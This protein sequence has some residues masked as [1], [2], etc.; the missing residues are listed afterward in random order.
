[1]GYSLDPS[2]EPRL[3]FFFRRNQLCNS[4]HQRYLSKFQKLI[5]YFDMEVPSEKDLEAARTYKVD[6]VP[7]LILL[8]RNGYEDLRW[9]GGLGPQPGLLSIEI[10]IAEVLPKDDNRQ[11]E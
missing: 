1:M 11:P 9:V 5:F 10:G 6:S 7:T 4:Y 2:I 8:D 3:L